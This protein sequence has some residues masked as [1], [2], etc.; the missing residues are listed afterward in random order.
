MESEPRRSSG[1]HRER[2]EDVDPDEWRLEGALKLWRCRHEDSWRAGPL[3]P[4][5]RV[6]EATTDDASRHTAGKEAADGSGAVCGGKGMDG[7]RG[8]RAGGPRE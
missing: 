8:G 3:E 1:S 4:C 6:E 7:R 2:R 5:G